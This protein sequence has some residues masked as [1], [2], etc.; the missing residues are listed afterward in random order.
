MHAYIRTYWYAL[1]Q[2]AQNVSIQK[3]NDKQLYRVKRDDMIEEIE[4][5]EGGWEV[6]MLLVYMWIYMHESKETTWAR[7]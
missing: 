4:N 6:M 7:K 5:M 1:T 3:E 2:F